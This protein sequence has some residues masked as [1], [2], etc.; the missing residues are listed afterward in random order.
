M[1]RV[2]GLQL[3]VDL[4]AGDHLRWPLLGARN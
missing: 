3:L 2:L 1:D 4:E